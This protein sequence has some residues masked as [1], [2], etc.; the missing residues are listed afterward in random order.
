MHVRARDKF[1]F[2]NMLRLVG[3]M[4]T[5]VEIA[6]ATLRLREKLESEQVRVKP[7]T[8]NKDTWTNRRYTTK[9]YD[10]KEGRRFL[11]NATK[12]IWKWAQ[13][14]PVSVRPDV[15]YNKEGRLELWW[16]E[17]QD[18]NLE[19]RSGHTQANGGQTRATA[20]DHQNVVG[21]EGPARAGHGKSVR[22]KPVFGVG[23]PPV[24][25]HAGTGA[26][27]VDEGAAVGGVS[28]LPPAGY[29]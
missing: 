11:K 4:P 23:V 6:L 8:V 15:F 12:N 29:V 3:S 9:L 18:A 25:H 16:W 17:G 5:P 22:R 13:Q 26:A 2:A 1:M 27:A 14:F 28:V 7:I 21:G 24:W 19:V 20:G 10:T